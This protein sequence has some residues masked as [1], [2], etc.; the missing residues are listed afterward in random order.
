MDIKHSYKEKENICK[1]NIVTFWGYLDKEDS[2]KKTIQSRDFSTCK[3]A[4]KASSTCS[5]SQ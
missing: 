5:T 1:L 4:K 2:E 3:K